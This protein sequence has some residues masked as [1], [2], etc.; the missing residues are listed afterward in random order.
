MLLARDRRREVHAA[1]HARRVIGQFDAALGA[2][3]DRRGERGVA[4]PGETIRDRLDVMIDAEDFLDD[5]DAALGPTGR[6]R[7]VGADRRSVGGVQI[8]HRT[9]AA[10]HFGSLIK[11]RRG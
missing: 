10:L 9:H 1:L 4:G 8:D 7:L 2:V 3:E 6:R 11:S 5:D